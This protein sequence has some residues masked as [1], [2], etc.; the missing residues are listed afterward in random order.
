MISSLALPLAEDAEESQSAVSGVL[1]F[2]DI[3]IVSLVREMVLFFTLID[4]LFSVPVSY[5]RTF[6]QK[7]TIDTGISLRLLEVLLFLFALFVCIQGRSGAEE[8]ADKS[9][10]EFVFTLDWP[11]FSFFGKDWGWWDC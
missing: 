11:M 4:L 6:S 7:K 5:S 2:S 9:A 8:E 10:A 3:M 1:I